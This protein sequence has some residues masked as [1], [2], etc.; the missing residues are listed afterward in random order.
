MGLDSAT[1]SN[2]YS[3]NKGASSTK[4]RNHF[5]S[6]HSLISAKLPA[7]SGHDNQT[8]IQNLADELSRLA[9]QSASKTEEEKTAQV[10]KFA[11]KLFT[12]LKTREDLVKFTESI[13]VLVSDAKDTPRVEKMLKKQ[14]LLFSLI[15]P[16][17]SPV[18][19]V[20]SNK[21]DSMNSL[22]YGIYTLIQHKAELPFETQNPT[23]NDEAWKLMEKQ[24]R[25]HINLSLLHPIKSCKAIIGFMKFA[26]AADNSRKS[27]PLPQDTIGAALRYTAKRSREAAG[28]FIN[29]KD[30]L[31][32]PDKTNKHNKGIKGFYE[33]LEDYSYNYDKTK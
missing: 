32:I 26:S 7:F 3:R 4:S 33:L 30:E 14:A 20:V 2:Y 1:P 19:F 11:L 31:G 25:T 23:A 10:D 12:Q 18:M 24:N 8:H 28:F 29:Y 15:Y 6:D 22:R 5:G 9:T 21:S 27:D 16:S 13:G 17:S